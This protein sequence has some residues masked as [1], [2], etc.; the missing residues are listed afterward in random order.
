M[1]R[2]DRFP[3][4]LIRVAG[5]NDIRP[6]ALQNFVDCAQVQQSA[7]TGCAREQRRM[8]RIDSRSSVRFDRSLPA[9]NNQHVLVVR[10]MLFDVRDII[11]DVALHA[12]AQRRVKLGEIA[13]LHRNAD[14]RLAIADFRDAAIIATSSP[15]SISKGRNF[16]SLSNPD[17]VISSSQ[18]AVSSASSSTTPILEMNSARDRARHAA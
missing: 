3:T 11:V 18:N 5:F 12:A 16:A 10:R 14:W 7:I 17:S 4:D 13:D 6:L 2:G 8:N 9:R 1:A 15:A